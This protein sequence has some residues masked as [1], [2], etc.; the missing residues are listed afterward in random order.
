MSIIYVVVVRLMRIF[1]LLVI[2]GS[3]VVWLAFS[4]IRNE[5]RKF[6]IGIT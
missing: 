1:A 2:A 4:C 3:T 6:S 5:N